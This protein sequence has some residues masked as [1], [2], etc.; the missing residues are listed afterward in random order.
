MDI[1]K[2]IYN[3]QL[4]KLVGKDIYLKH[5]EAIGII[6]QAYHEHFKN[7]NHREETSF[8]LVGVLSAEIYTAGDYTTFDIDVLLSDD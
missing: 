6:S 8:V 5:T 3:K 2:E 1:N 4:R 7:R